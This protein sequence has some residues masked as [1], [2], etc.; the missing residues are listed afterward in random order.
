MKNITPKAQKLREYALEAELE[1]MKVSVGLKAVVVEGKGVTLELQLV[2][3]A[4]EDVL[5]DDLHIIW[6]DGV[7]SGAEGE[8]TG[9]PTT[10]STDVVDDPATVVK[11][12]SGTV[13]V[14]DD[15]VMVVQ[16]CTGADVTSRC[17]VGAGTLF[18]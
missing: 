5:K 2:D 4:T 7:V 17:S 10:K 15:Q 14:W 9:L 13:L 3:F 8:V 12:T 11:P 18:C 6:D 16:E 1:M